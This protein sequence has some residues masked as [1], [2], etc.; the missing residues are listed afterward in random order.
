MYLRLYFQAHLTEIVRLIGYAD[1]PVDEA[2]R[3][4]EPLVARF[5]KEKMVA[6]FQE[7][8][9]VDTDRQPNV[10]RLNAEARRLSFQILGPPPPSI[11]SGRAPSAM[12][13]TTGETDLKPIKMPRH[14]VMGKYEEHLAT[15][16]LQFTKHAEL[17]KRTPGLEML[18]ALDYLVVRGKMRLLV[19]I[20]PALRANQGAQLIAYSDALLA[21]HLPLSVWPVDSPT[22]WVWREQELFAEPLGIDPKRFKLSLDD[23]QIVHDHRE[24]EKNCGRD[25]LKEG[26]ACACCRAA[27]AILTMSNSK[28]HAG[29]KK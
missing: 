17:A 24:G 28:R 11:P 13:R 18:P 27:R 16:K 3:R 20:R 6:A 8:V 23:W 19:A 5:G 21:N 7:I 22:G 1:V 4:L 12:T 14:Y 10:A 26:C 9:E 15:N 25:W 29:G 2:R